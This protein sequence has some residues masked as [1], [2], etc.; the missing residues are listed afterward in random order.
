MK[1]VACLA[2]FALA[3]CMLG[4]NI[5]LDLASCFMFTGSTEF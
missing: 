4:S 1:C 2:I 5:C 3:T